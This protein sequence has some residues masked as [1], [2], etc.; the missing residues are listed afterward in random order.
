MIL[1]LVLILIAIIVVVWWFWKISMRDPKFSDYDYRQDRKAK[2]QI[3]KQLKEKRKD[4]G[5]KN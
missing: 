1:K 2:K 3:E 5:K 4:D